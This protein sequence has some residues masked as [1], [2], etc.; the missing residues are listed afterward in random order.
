MSLELLDKTRKINRLLNNSDSKIVFDELSKVISE[1]SGSEVMVLSKK[2]KLLGL[3]KNPSVETMDSLALVNKGDFLESGLNERFLNVLSTKENVN[4]AILGFS[5]LVAKRYRAVIIPIVVTGE[6]LGTL[7]IY[8]ENTEYSVDDIILLEYSATVVGLETLRAVSE[9]EREADRQSELAKSAFES[10]SYSEFMAVKSVFLK[11]EG[12][13]GS[14]VASK[15]SKEYNITRSII[16][17][18]LK[19][20]ES[21]GVIESHSAGAKGTYI[22]VL[23]QNLFDILNEK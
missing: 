22:N 7:F 19:K 4:L 11:F 12:F 13:S 14:I 5:D 23:N 1:L 10:L 16:V 2:G 21:A 3:G 18:A 9:E 8:R 6:R 15:I 17:N 20:L